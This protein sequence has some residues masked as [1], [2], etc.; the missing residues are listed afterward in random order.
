MP[1]RN[2]SLTREL[3]HSSRSMKP[4]LR[5]IS[6]GWPVGAGRDPMAGFSPV[7]FG[8]NEARRMLATWWNGG[9]SIAGWA[10]LIARAA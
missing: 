6:K 4:T 9:V 10:G 1:T 7:G 5:P 2:I 8:K 3:D